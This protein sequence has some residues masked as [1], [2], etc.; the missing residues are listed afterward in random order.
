[1]QPAEDR[2]GADCMR[3]SAAMA[4]IWICVVEIGER[5]AGS[6]ISLCKWRSTIRLVDTRE[7]AAR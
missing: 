3:F 5:T 7:S 4:R 2:I 1:M 6:L